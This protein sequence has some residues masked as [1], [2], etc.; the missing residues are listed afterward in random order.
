MKLNIDDIKPNPNNPRTIKDDNFK[1]LVRSIKE[2]PEFLEA[3]EVIVNQ[4]HMILGGNMRYKAAIEAGYKEIPVKV[5]D[6]SEEK[7]RRFIIKDNVA[8]GDW[9]WDILANEWDL[10]ELDAW[11]LDVSAYRVEGEVEEDE[12]PE[13][14]DKEPPKSKLGEVY[15]L[16]RH[17]VMCG[18]ST[19][20]ANVELLMNGEK[21]DMVFTDPPYSVNYTKKNKE[22]LGS[23]DYTE[24]KND[25]LSVDD[26]AK[27]IWKPVFDNLAEVAKDDCSIYCTM[28]QGGDQM[29]MMMMMDRWQV[30]H[31][32]IWVKESPVFS[33]NRLDYDYK[34]E[35]IAYGWMKKHNW[36]GK[37]EHTKSVWEIHRDGDKSHP[38]MKPIALIANALLNSTKTDDLIVDVFLGSGSTLIACEQTDRTCYG[39]EL[40]PKYVDVIRKRYVKFVNNGELPDNWEELTPVVQ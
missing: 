8:G 26:T 36:Y 39:M 1:K 11:G 20:R 16:G 28:P 4:D 24:I 34:H 18:D 9:D 12:V 13:V 15:Q 37:G 35:P 21:A 19:D 7:Q 32:L 40:D 2:D 10:D 29:M 23:K 31:E 14:D 17:R 38:T 25:N 30:K 27:Q 5:V 3:R 22:I 33:M 6:W